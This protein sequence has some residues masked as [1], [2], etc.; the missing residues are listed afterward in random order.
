MEKKTES[1]VYAILLAAGLSERFGSENKLLAQFRGKPLARHTLDLARGMGIEFFER[2]FF[3][4]SDERVAALVNGDAAAN[5]T[6]LANNA[7]PARLLP[8]TLIRN[9]APEKGQ[10]ES[11][12]LGTEAASA[13]D[14]DYLF[15]FPCDQPFLD[16]DTVR[17][18]LAARRP[19]CIV[20]PYPENSPERLACSGDSPDCRGESLGR[21][22][23]P[24]LFSGVFRNELMSLREGEAP[25]A[26]K[27]RHSQALI[28][29]PVPNPL[30]LADI[31]NKAMLG[32]RT[33]SN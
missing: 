6:F 24:S 25:R 13:S 1:K 7:A 18:I 30:T 20:E 33:D 8:I 17:L 9:N 5:S 15:F 31:D 27:M 23:S 4:Y 29:V 12:R 28:R 16:A 22:G 32:A 2:I 10:G 14:G 21:G 3:V 19:G 26:I 11:V